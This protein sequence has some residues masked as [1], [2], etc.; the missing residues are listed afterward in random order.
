MVA[1]C[2]TFLKFEVDRLGLGKRMCVHA[3]GVRQFLEK[4][5]FSTK[6][7]PTRVTKHNIGNDGQIIIST[8]ITISCAL[9]N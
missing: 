6:N 7:P 5:P 3:S 1:L 8:N 4:I 2:D 9:V